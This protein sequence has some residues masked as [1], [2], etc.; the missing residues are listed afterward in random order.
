MPSELFDPMLR[1]A[2]DV[3]KRGRRAKPPIPAPAKVAPILKFKK[4]S[5]KAKEAI[6]ETV[7]TDEEFRA[8]VAEAATE[9][10]VGR[11]G[12]MFLERPDGWRDF[13]DTMVDAA[14]EPVVE[15]SSQ[16]ARLED[17]VRVAEGS[18]DAARSDLAEADE[19][20]RARDEEI[21]RLRGEVKIAADELAKVRKVNDE[22]S[23]Q[24]QRAVGELKHTEEVMVRHVTERKRLEALVATMTAAQLST[25]QV[26]GAVTNAEVRSALD[27]METTL[28]E[29]G[30][31][32]ESLRGSAT[33]EAVPVE[34]RVPLP[35][36]HGLFDDSLDYAEYLLGIPGMT[37]LVDGYNV[38]KEADPNKDLDLQREWL[39]NGLAAL[40][41]RCG[42]RFEVVFDGA[43]V[44]VPNTA[45]RNGVR[46]RFT[47]AAVEADDEIIAM[48]A[49][50]DRTKPVTVVSTD[51]R[52]R[53]GAASGGA[54][55][56]YSRQLIDLV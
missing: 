44:A 50:M 5:T 22:L 17:A 46:C 8:R 16:I 25:N 6:Y 21:E 20:L 29:L 7:D 42:A 32:M 23:A 39:L 48:V 27:D 11:I 9:A 12:M 13:V 24:R 4:I 28:G 49:A 35:V 51:K 41:A 18:R 33:P 40:A 36:P 38:T 45:G 10:K 3:A 53:A 19:R 54:N 26:G 30:Q 31:Q 52:V 56:L 14:E 1:F 15:S 34:R 2:L 55:V 47:T 37:V 43:D